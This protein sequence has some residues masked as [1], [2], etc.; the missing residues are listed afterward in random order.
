M[1]GKLG[2]R[3]EGFDFQIVFFLPQHFG[4]VPGHL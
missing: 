1:K 4:N 3:G 2:F